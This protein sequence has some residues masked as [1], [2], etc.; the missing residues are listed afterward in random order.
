MRPPLCVKVC[1]AVGAGLDAALDLGSVAVKEL[2]PV[3]AGG[4]AVVPCVPVEVCDALATLYRALGYDCRIAL[5]VQVTAVD[6]NKLVGD[7]LAGA[8]GHL[9]YS[10]HFYSLH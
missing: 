8:S 7:R 4:N 1:E 3:F 5:K 2:V 9:C 10:C 6:D